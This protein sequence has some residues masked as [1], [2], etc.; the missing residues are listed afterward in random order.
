VI[1]NRIYKNSLPLKNSKT[2]IINRIER[3]FNAWD[4]RNNLK[5]YNYAKRI[6]RILQM[7]RNGVYKDVL[8]YKCVVKDLLV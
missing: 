1:L 8:G 4:E 7:I 6:G 2:N 3:D 5:K